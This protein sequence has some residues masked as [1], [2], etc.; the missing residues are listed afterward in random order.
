MAVGADWCPCAT[1]VK[2]MKPPTVTRL[3]AIAGGRAAGKTGLVPCFPKALHRVT[4]WFSR[5][6][7]PRASDALKGDPPPVGPRRPV[8]C[9][10]TIYCTAEKRGM[11]VTPHIARLR[12]IGARPEIDFP[13]RVVIDVRYIESRGFWGDVKILRQTAS[14]ERSKK[15]SVEI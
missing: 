6:E 3:I 14:V 1:Q 13:A 7:M 11:V 9:D 8:S 5:P 12:N 10:V 4:G 2:S 15:R